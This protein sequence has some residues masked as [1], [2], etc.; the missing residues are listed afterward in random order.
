MHCT[1]TQSMCVSHNRQKME[2][3]VRTARK[4]KLDYAQAGNLLFVS[5]GST[6]HKQQYSLPGGPY[7][8]FSLYFPIC[9][10]GN[11]CHDVLQ[12]SPEGPGL[13]DAALLAAASR[14][15]L[16]TFLKLAGK[17]RWSCGDQDFRKFHCTSRSCTSNP[18]KNPNP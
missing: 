9:E 3:G 1:I 14:R 17:E 5:I 12:N 2:P 11:P 7:S 8:L 4:R 16:A 13:P 6:T 15:S 10:K 18:N